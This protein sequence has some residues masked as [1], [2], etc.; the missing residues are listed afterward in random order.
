MPSS[1]SSRPGAR[2]ARRPGGQPHNNNALK[3]GFYA[4]NL[5][6]ADTAGLEDLPLDA[7]ADEINLLRVLIRRVAEKTG[8]DQPLEE[9]MAHLRLITFALTCLARLMRTQTYIG[10]NPLE[11]HPMEALLNQAIQQVHSQWAAKIASEG[12]SQNFFPQ[13]RTSSL[14]L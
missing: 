13:R 6:A 8:P 10:I 2:P 3:H 14:D 4:R 11:E 9:S 12:E 1:R 7:L 5:P